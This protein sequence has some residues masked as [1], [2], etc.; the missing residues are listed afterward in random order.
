M[1]RHLFLEGP[2]QTGKS[3]LLRRLLAPYKDQIGGFASQRMLNDDGRTIGYRI[4]PA[5][6][7]PLTIP[8]IEGCELPGIFRII[9]EDG[10]S[11]K[12]PEIFDS[13]GIR[14]LDAAREKKLILLDEI[15]GAELL[16]TKFRETLY[17]VLPGDIPCIGVIKL[18]SKASFMSKTAGYSN[19]VI[20]YNLQLRDKLITEYGG[21]ILS[22]KR[23]DA[24]LKKE[25]EDFICGIFT[26]ER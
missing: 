26:T 15:G 9:H 24:D 23:D 8:F 7:T 10:T 16:N 6:S 18:K 17:D 21:R 14:L 25:T 1:Y 20:E 12:F 19:T 22:F 4:G 5:E 13:Y 11:E 3:T 2:I